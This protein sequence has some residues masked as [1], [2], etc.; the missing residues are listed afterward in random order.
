MLEHFGVGA[1]DLPGKVQIPSVLER[2][3]S[4]K[5]D[6][7]KGA[8]DRYQGEGDEFHEYWHENHSG[9]FNLSKKLPITFFSATIR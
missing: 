2:G 9:S 6:E 5:G 1:L 8:E 4:A 7:G 3:A